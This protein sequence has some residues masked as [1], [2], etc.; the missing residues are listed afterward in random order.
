MSC[1]LPAVLARR[2]GGAFVFDQHD[3]VPEL[4][5]SR[6]HRG[7]AAGYVACRVL[8]SCTYRLAD[9]VLAP[10]ESY[11]RVALGRGRRDPRD[12]FVVRSAPDTR[13]FRPVPPDLDLKRGRKYLL[14]YLG[15]MGPQDGVDFALRALELLKHRRCDW[16]ATFIGSGDMLPEMRRLS[17]SLGLEECVEFTGRIP[18]GEL[19]T[20]LSTADVGLAPDPRNPLNDASTMDK[21]GEYMALGIPIVSFDLAESQVTAGGAAVYATRNDPSEFADRIDELLSDPDLRRA[22]GQAGRRRIEDDLSWD[23]SAAALI[24]AYDRAMVLRGVTR[25]PRLRRRPKADARA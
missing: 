2:R 18:N 5:L 17:W 20:R 4:C 24:A 19:L 23:H 10:N 16:H 22:M 7:R 11:R 15:V 25:T 3:L 12:V 13:T 21:I 9:V 14:V 1:F 8:E 6:F